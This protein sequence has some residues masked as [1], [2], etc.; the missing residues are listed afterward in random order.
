MNLLLKKPDVWGAFA[1]GLCLVHCV[2]TP[3]LFVLS[4]CIG[5]CESVAPFWWK[6]FDYIFLV[7][8]FLAVFQSTRTTGSTIIKF[9]MWFSWMALVALLINEKLE[10]FHVT[11]T[12]VFIASISL[13]VLHLCNRKFC[14]CKTDNCC[15]VNG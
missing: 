12:F 13:V 6:Q 2:A 11:E 3:L 5:D 10:I 14:K 8:S 7:I 1:S 15:S 4:T 9:G